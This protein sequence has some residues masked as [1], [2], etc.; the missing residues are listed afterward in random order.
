MKM[1][2]YDNRGK[3]RWVS[4]GTVVPIGWY[5]GNCQPIET[6]KKVVLREGGDNWAYEQYPEK[7]VYELKLVDNK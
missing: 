2:V 6:E 3:E 4:A 1:R 5:D 7:T